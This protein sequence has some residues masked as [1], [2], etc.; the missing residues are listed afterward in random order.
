MLA[1]CIPSGLTEQAI[2]TSAGFLAQQLDSYVLLSTQAGCAEDQTVSLTEGEG[3]R[4]EGTAQLVLFAGLCQAKLDN[5]QAVVCE[6]AGK[7]VSPQQN[8][9]VPFCELRLLQLI[10]ALCKIS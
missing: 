6:T 9:S 5:G 2:Y 4:E 3:E 1:Q 7:L 8:H 10:P